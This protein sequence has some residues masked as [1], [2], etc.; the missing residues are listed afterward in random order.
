MTP[1]DLICVKCKHFRPISGGCN[2][3]KDDIPNEIIEKNKHDE[4]LQDQKNNIV[5]EE[6]QSEEAKLFN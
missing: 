5:F 4:P 3:F 6:G 1:K 2:A